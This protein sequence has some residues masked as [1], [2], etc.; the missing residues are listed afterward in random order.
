[1]FLGF[2]SCEGD[3]VTGTIRYMGKDKTTQFKEQMPTV[4]PFAVHVRV[5]CS[6][7][8]IHRAINCMGT[9]RKDSRA[10]LLLDF[11]LLNFKFSLE[12]TTFVVY[13]NFYPYCFSEVS[14]MD[15]S[16]VKVFHTYN[17]N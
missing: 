15:V 13:K 1:M 5:F 12:F 11:V 4:Q 8:T 10:Y 3:L 17:N 9:K 7:V 6:S 14:Q 2:H 16:I